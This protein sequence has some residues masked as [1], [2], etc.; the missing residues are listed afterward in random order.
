MVL[1][2]LHQVVARKFDP[3]APVWLFLVGYLQVYVIQALSFHDWAVE[4]RGKDLVTA[5]NFRSFWALLWF[6]LVYQL[7][8]TRIAARVLPQPPRRWSPLLPA[9]ICPPLIVWG[10][11]CANMFVEGDAPT[12]ENFSSEEALFRSFP[13]VMLVA[14]VMLV[15][16]GRTTQSVRPVFLASR[17]TDR[18]RLRRDLDV[19]RQA[20]PLAHGFA[21]DDL[22][23]LPH[24]SQTPVM[25]RLDHH[26]RARCS[27]RDDR[28]RLA[29][30]LQ[31]SADR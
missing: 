30:S 23:P 7:A 17:A 11:F 15:I 22:C 29:G 9:V 24:S 5:A 25:A 14:A 28:A 19:Q 27:G 4:V 13:F 3:F 31:L 21:R 18:G 6:L 12:F 1:Y 26:W 2:F 16:T 8:P 10:L 20:I